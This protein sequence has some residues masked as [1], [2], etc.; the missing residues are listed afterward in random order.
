M[1]P[2]AAAADAL[3]V[4][5]STAGLAD[6]G[7]R[8]Q[9]AGAAAVAARLIPVKVG[10]VDDTL[11]PPRLREPNWIIWDPGNVSVAF[12]SVLAGL[13]SDPDRRALSRRLS[14]EADAWVLAGRIDAF[15]IT[16]YPRARQMAQVLADLSADKL[17]APTPAMR[18]FVARSVKVSRPR[19]RRRRSR[20]FYGAVGAAIAIVT[21]AVAVPAIANSSLSTRNPSSPPATPT[22]CRICPSGRPRTPPRCCSTARRPSA[23]WPR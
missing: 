1:V 23:P 21:V 13:L 9:L 18:Q 8:D 15:L 14:H 17:A 6:A 20:A 7:W 5:L 19:H 12:G 2:T 10:T 3:V 4:F 22:S 11:V 16:D